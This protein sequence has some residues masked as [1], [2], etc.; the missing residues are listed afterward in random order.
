MDNDF[1]N[2]NHSLEQIS[3]VKAIFTK[4]D[5][6]TGLE[7]EL[8]FSDCFK[9][10][11]HNRDEQFWSEIFPDNQTECKEIHEKDSFKKADDL[12]SNSNSGI[13]DWKRWNENV[14][15]DS[16]LLMAASE[17]HQRYEETSYLKRPDMKLFTELHEE[18]DQMIQ[19]LTAE[20]DILKLNMSTRMNDIREYVTSRNMGMHE[21][22]QD[23]RYIYLTESYQNLD[24]SL[25]RVNF[26]IACLK[27]DNILIRNLVGINDSSV[28]EESRGFAIQEVRDGLDNPQET[29]YFVNETRAL[30]SL[31]QFRPEHWES[32]HIQEQKNCIENLANYNAEILGIREKPEIR[33]YCNED[34]VDYG[35]Y[36]R[37][38]NTISI[39]EFNVNNGIETADTI[40][41]EYRH[42][43]Q[44]ERAEKMENNRDLEFRNGFENYIRFEDDYSGYKN[45]LVEV[46][47]SAYAT[48]FKKKISE[49][50]N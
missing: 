38:S 40:S 26:R 47:A 13:N 7:S 50:N 43:Y 32:L 15:S 8:D 5:S 22:K 20:K 19:R 28:N 18:N 37:S 11:S 39:N 14:V 34:P 3:D 27:E 17:L 35:S 31:G 46:D 36:S 45:Q 42:C 33:Y 30:E 48:A 23:Q 41:H 2:R 12:D 29:N 4:V 24:K 1:E 6:G 49:I 10:E 9:Q 16:S 21:S 44:R 25:E